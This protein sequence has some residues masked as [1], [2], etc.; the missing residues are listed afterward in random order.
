MT[1]SIGSNVTSMTARATSLFGGA[2]DAFKA[3]ADA[4]VNPQA[5]S[6]AAVAEASARKGRRGTILDRYA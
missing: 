3:I 6:P 4:A 1:N 5:E 2:K